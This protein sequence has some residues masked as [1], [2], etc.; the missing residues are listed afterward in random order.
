MI[1]PRIEKIGQ[2]EKAFER[3]VLT[4]AIQKKIYALPGKQ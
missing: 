2:G 3:D 1:D 4:E